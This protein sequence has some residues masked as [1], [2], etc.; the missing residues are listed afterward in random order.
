MGF[1]A[2]R[3]ASVAPR[4]ARRAVPAGSRLAG[5]AG[6]RRLSLRAATRMSQRLCGCG[7]GLFAGVAL[8][9]ALAGCT[10]HPVD[11]IDESLT[12]APVAFTAGERT[13]EINPNAPFVFEVEVPA[14]MML[15]V[16][17]QPDGGATVGVEQ[18]LAPDGKRFTARPGAKVRSA[19]QR[20]EVA[21][22]E[23]EQAGLGL[24]FRGRADTGGTWRMALAVRPTER[25]GAL[26]ERAQRANVFEQ[27]LL[28]G[29][30]LS[31][32]VRRGNAS[33]VLRSIFP[34]VATLFESVRVKVT[35]RVAAAADAGMD[36]PTPDAP[37]SSGG[38]SP[39]SAIPTRVTTQRIAQTGDAVPEQPGARFTYF[40]NPIIDPEG[41]VAFWGAYAGGGGQ[42]GLYVWDGGPLR[43]VIDDDPALNDGRGLK[44]GEAF[45]DF[46]I[47]Y[48]LGAPHMTWGAAGRLIFAAHVNASPLPNA[49]FRWRAGDGDLLRVTDCDALRELIP[50][51]GDTFLC[52]FFHPSVSDAGRVVF[53][54]RYTYFNRAGQLVFR[55]RGLFSSNGLSVTPI[56]AP[57]LVTPGTVPLQGPHAT[58]SDV[59]PLPIIAA[60]G[61]TY[62]Q[63]SYE[64]GARGSHG[65]YRQ[66][67]G[68][69]S[70]LM[71]NG[72]STF[73]GLTVFSSVG[74]DDR[75]YAS[76]AVNDSGVVGLEVTLTNSAGSRP[77]VIL[78]DGQRW[79]QVRGANRDATDLL[80]G[81][82]RAGQVV[83]LAGGRPFVGDAT[84][85][86]D[87]AA[88]PSPEIAPAGAVW[89]SFGGAINSAGRALLRYRR[90]DGSAP[91]LA[92]WTGQR[93]LIVADAAQRLPA[94]NFSELLAAENPEL[95]AVDRAGVLKDRPELDRSTRS[96]ALNDRDQMVFR[97]AAPG[98]DAQRDTADDYQAIYL[99]LGQ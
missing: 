65:V 66:R 97:V 94:S 51:A 88:A 36:E 40:S 32:D 5:H 70:A 48:D 96:G 14:G 16:D 26:R 19:D 53:A 33:P 4:H 60:N 47:G 18:A 67:G 43:R 98:D 52:E 46:V 34:D 10:L 86:V 92:F 74:P 1:A 50:E 68:E 89:E 84:Q 22:M 45:G 25:L 13:E 9:A 24:R 85:A 71:N 90:G 28:L 61:D 80:S 2:D 29:Y 95:G 20:F 3:T 21:P 75:P 49:L 30:V 83:F 76:M 78:Y 31:G 55:H 87:L 93:L 44:P 6:A 15:E 39:G 58:F 79:R 27:A 72:S 37:P 63:A 8:C 64:Q 12:P 81:I 56:V 17:A 11:L 41:R 82:N 7:G 69:L 62:F 99:G 91:G 42:A 73:P 23:S 38:D 54:G 57:E 59:Q 77:A 35:V